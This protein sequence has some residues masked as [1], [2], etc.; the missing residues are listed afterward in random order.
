MAF[1]ISVEEFAARTGAFYNVEKRFLHATG[2]ILRPDG[3]VDEAVYSTGPIGR[4][5]AA[6]VLKLIDYRSK[7]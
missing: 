5:P 1:D 3:T 4:L 2:L 6:D 7:P